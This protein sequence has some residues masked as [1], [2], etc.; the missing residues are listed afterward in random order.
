[1]TTLKKCLFD[2]YYKIDSWDKS[3]YM[4]G[5]FGLLATVS[6]FFY[7]YYIENQLDN[8]IF[9]VYTFLFFQIMILSFFAIVLFVSDKYRVIKLKFNR[10]T[11]ILYDNTTNF[12]NISLTDVTLNM[13][14]ESI[15]DLSKS[16]DV[17]KEAGIHF[18]NFFDGELARKGND[19]NLE[20]KLKKWVE[21]DS[22][23][24]IGKFEIIGDHSL[25][26]KIKISH[27]FIG[28]CPI[29]GPNKKCSFLRGYVEGFSSNLFTKDLKSKCN[30]HTNPPYCIFT[31]CDNRV[32]K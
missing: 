3:D 4:L 2:I 17:G 6:A 31:L 25:P 22:S 14:I 29:G 1:M 15:E 28:N 16:H 20:A 23:S 11:G 7:F 18:Y 21:Y 32:P 10:D 19:Y 30:H 9:F 26:I 12:R 24:G 5:I 13:I 27:P 8:S